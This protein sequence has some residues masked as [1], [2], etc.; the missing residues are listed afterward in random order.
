MP[1]ELACLPGFASGYEAKADLY[2]PFDDTLCSRLIP[3]CEI[4]RGCEI[5]GPDLACLGEVTCTVACNKFWPQPNEKLQSYM[6]KEI[7]ILY[8]PLA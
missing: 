7:T 6:I 4:G 1:P 8:V 3:W 5:P 2:W